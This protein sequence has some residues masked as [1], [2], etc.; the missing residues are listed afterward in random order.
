MEIVVFGVIAIC[1]MIAFE[2]L[3]RLRA[4]KATTSPEI[5]AQHEKIH[6]ALLSLNE[7]MKDLE[8]DLSFEADRWYDLNEAMLEYVTGFYNNKDLDQ[9]TKFQGASSFL[10][11]FKAGLNDALQSESPLNTVLEITEKLKTN[12]PMYGINPQ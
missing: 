2:Y 5:T 8:G 12:K 9:D 6:G 4:A 10:V 11:G 3:Q 7:Y 1:L